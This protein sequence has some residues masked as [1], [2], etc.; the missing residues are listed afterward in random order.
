[1]SSAVASRKKDRTFTWMSAE[2][3]VKGGGSGDVG[4]GNVFG[5]RTLELPESCDAKQCSS[6]DRQRASKSAN[7]TGTK[8]PHHQSQIHDRTNGTCRAG[9]NN[10]SNVPWPLNHPRAPV[11]LS[12]ELHRSDNSEVEPRAL[13]LCPLR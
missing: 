10:A 9:Q 12:D 4:D 7:A 5:L 2:W 3:R 6:R 8:Q 11:F 1:M 13:L